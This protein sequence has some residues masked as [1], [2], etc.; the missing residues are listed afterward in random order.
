MRLALTRLIPTL[1]VTG[2]TLGATAGATAF[3][4]H[5]AEPAKPAA[6]P[7]KGAAAPAANPPPV[8]A[9]IPPCTTNPDGLGVSRIVEIDTTGGPGFG[10]EHYKAY[11]FLQTKEVVLTFDDG[12]WPGSTKSVLETLAGHCT[13]GTFFSIGKHALYHPEILKLVAAAG[14]TVG[15]HTFS[16]VDLS[17]MEPD[18]A[19]EEIEKG[20]SAVKLALGAAPASFFR[21]PL[22]RDPP[23][24]VAY[25]GSRNVGIFS[26]DI[27]SFDFK[28]GKK[29][30]A[31]VKTVMDK[32]EKKGKGIILMHDFQK[33]LAAALPQLLAELKAK[34]Y[35]VVHLKSKVQAT[36]IATFDADIEKGAK[37]LVTGAAAG[38]SAA[39]VI[40]TIADQ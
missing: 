10:F 4:L 38:A 6:A 5:A 33:S 16:H 1:M 36:T 18:K 28:F 19:K 27:D 25:L 8:V 22:L 31:I 7:G 39:S 9:K 15:T 21:F 29:P 3:A 24:M 2:L 32:L 11:D 26:T 35:K 30:E 17:K 12:P 23:D 37:G 14:H 34:G 13:K 20:F 40:R